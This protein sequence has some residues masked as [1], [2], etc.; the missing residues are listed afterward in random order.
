VKG[1][2]IGNP[3]RLEPLD[4]RPPKDRHLF[5][6][7]LLSYAK[8][9][10]WPV[11]TTAELYDILERHLDGDEKAKVELAERLDVVLKDQP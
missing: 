10:N 7:E 11:L 3:W 9:N 6:P 5:A 2:I 1:A 4:N 8:I